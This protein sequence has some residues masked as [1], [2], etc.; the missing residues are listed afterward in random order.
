[1]INTA[2][3]VREGGVAFGAKLTDLQAG[4]DTGV[5][6]LMR[7][8]Q[9]FGPALS[10]RSDDGMNS[11][12]AFLDIVPVSAL[13]GQSGFSGSAASAAARLSLLSGFRGEMQATGIRVMSVLTGP[14]DDAWHQS[15]PQPKVAPKQ[16]ARTVVAAL[17]NGQEISCAGDVAIE[18]FERWR[19][20]PLLTMREE[21]R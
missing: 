15:L 16:L 1:M 17:Q 8:A 2:G 21:N 9:A 13:A 3:Q 4:L 18:M 19:A 7:L 12:A 5:V 20:N 11:A 6:G 14:V 10:A